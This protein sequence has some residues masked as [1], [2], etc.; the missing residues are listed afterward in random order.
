MDLGKA[1]KKIAAGGPAP[2]IEDAFE[3]DNEVPDE[4]EDAKDD[5]SEDITKDSLIKVAKK[6]K[7]PAAA[8]GTA[9]AKAKPKAKASTKKS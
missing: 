5:D 2:D 4:P 3:V 9:G 7:G 6:K 8:K 1:P